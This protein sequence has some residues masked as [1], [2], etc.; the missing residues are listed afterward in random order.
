MKLS[1]S[2][3]CL[4]STS[5]TTREHEFIYVGVKKE[6]TIQQKVSVFIP[7]AIFFVEFNLEN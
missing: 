5:V 3:N 2:E 7:P 4:P 6:L 1:N